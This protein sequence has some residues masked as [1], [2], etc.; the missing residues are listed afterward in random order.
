[1]VWPIIAAVAGT[2]IGAFGA[3]SSYRS[4]RDAGEREEQLMRQ[5]GAFTLQESIFEALKIRENTRLK[6]GTA[7]AQYAG[8]GV[9]GGS[10]ADVINSINYKG[11]RDALWMLYT[12]ELAEEGYIRRGAATSSI[13]NAQ[14][15]GNLALNV[16]N[17]VS[18]LASV[19][20]SSGKT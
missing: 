5:E 17:M 18:N 4:S 6:T 16:G 9:V 2:V 8:A 3:Y 15:T 12:G 20:W 1:M 10:T 7:R 11:Q 13:A 14:A 19:D